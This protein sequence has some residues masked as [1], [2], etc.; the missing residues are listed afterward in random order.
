MLRPQCQIGEAK[1][2][3]SRPWS[4]YSRLLSNNNSPEFAKASFSLN[5]TYDLLDRSIN[6]IKKF[7]KNI[8]KGNRLWYTGDIIIERYKDYL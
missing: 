7:K 8:D 1:R 3:Q 5:D 6:P 4:S 2:T